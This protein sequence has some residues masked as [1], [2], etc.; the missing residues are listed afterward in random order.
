MFNSHQNLEYVDKNSIIGPNFS[1]LFHK[2][3]SKILV[4]EPEC[5][6]KFSLRLLFVS[7]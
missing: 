3:F 7:R 2:E 5:C 4:F 1:L 6:K